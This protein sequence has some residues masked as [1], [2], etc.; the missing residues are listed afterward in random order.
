[1]RFKTFIDLWRWWFKKYHTKPNR[2]LK[3]VKRQLTKRQADYEMRHNRQ[4]GGY[5]D[6]H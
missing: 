3:S 2:H 1:M 5:D 4:I 6:I